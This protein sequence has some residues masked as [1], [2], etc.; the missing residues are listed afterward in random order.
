VWL[1]VIREIRNLYPQEFQ[2]LP[3]YGHG[4]HST[5]HFDRLVGS[6]IVREAIDDG[7][8]LSEILQPEAR[9]CRYFIEK[10]KEFLLYA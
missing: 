7:A 10:R 6:S 5:Y 8:E 4:M 9:F 3:P 2:W 1:S